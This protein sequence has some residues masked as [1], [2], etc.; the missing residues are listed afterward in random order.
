M[1]PELP[2][3]AQQL[4]YASDRISR[5]V[6]GEDVA[7]LIFGPTGVGK[8]HLVDEIC[9]RFAVTRISCTNM[10]KAG[11]LKTLF[12]HRTG[13]QLLLVED[14]DEFFYKVEFCNL[15]KQVTINEPWRTIT[16]LNRI[17]LR[18]G[19]GSFPTDCRIIVLTNEDPNQVTA[20]MRSHVQA[21]K[22]RCPVV[23]ISFDPIELLRYIDY[24]V[25]SLDYL[26]R[27][28]FS[29]ATSQDILDTYHRYAWRLEN[30]DFRSLNMFA[31]EA[32]R[33]PDRWKHTITGI[34]R[35]LPIRDDEAPLAP[36][37]VPWSRRSEN[38]ATLMSAG[39][40]ASAG[41]TRPEPAADTEDMSTQDANR[42]A[43]NAGGGDILVAA[44]KKKPRPG[45]A[46]IRAESGG[47]RTQ[48]L[49]RSSAFRE[50]FCGGSAISMTMLQRGHKNVWLNDVDRS[51]YFL[52]RG[53]QQYPGRFKIAARKFVPTIRGFKE[54]LDRLM[55][56]SFEVEEEET[57]IRT[58]IMKLALQK[59][60]YGSL[61][62]AASAPRGG[63]RQTDRELARN[64]N[65]ESICRSIDT[66]SSHLS[67]ARITNL[68]Y[69]A[70]IQDE[71]ERAILYLDPPYVAVGRRLYQ[72]SF[73]E[74]DHI[75][76]CNLL[77]QTPHAWVLSLNDHEMVHDL[78]AGFSDIRRV[79]TTYSLHNH[80]RANELLITARPSISDGNGQR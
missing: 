40:P 69:A 39:D 70:L 35:L 23:P 6:R 18:D 30:I 13:Q 56:N 78:Y 46:P 2:L 58:A 60:S 51:I 73:S 8:S 41:F 26:R 29:L 36:R 71:T 42:L 1:L 34:L 3:I 20:R 63:W 77:R 47:L 65:A 53:Y 49:N 76:L 43:Q 72:H 59:L 11:F 9:R 80:R 57:I 54:A 27:W 67:R 12:D 14:S 68:D 64:W 45:S 24:Q 48:F 38:P 21:L 75:R 31:E 5:V 19:W 15:L 55:E 17:A 25:C 28:R 44:F 66:I 10:T 16:T 4:S 62:N 37:I 61:V 32:L 7:V 52:L 74:K 33:Y 79:P 50:P 22:G